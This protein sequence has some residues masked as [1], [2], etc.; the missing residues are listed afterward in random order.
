MD[1][2]G[3]VALSGR[4]GRGRICKLGLGV[5]DAWHN[6]RARL[7]GSVAVASALGSGRV[8]G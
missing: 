6:I 5:V 2:V 4:V 3:G 8:R 7:P 1:M